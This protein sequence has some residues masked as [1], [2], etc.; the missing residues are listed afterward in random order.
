MTELAHW[1]SFCVIVGSAA[2]GLIGLMFVVLTLIAQRPPPR[3]A[4]AGGAFASPTIAHFSAV[5]LLTVLLRM[6]WQ[7]IT[8]A[9]FA[10]GILGAIGAVYVFIVHRRM[11]QQTSYKL[12]LEDWV[13]HGALPLAAYAALAIS[14]LIAPSVP[15]EALFVVAAGALLL[16]FTGIHNAWDGVVYHTLVHRPASGK[17]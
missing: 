6:P 11:H 3:A 13:F 5:L 12:D 10:W 2:G 17:S 16:L 4:E 14:A 15:R 7:E 8:T 9:A 1:D